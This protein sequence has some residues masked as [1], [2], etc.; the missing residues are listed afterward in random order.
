MT[1]I[2]ARAEID[3][4]TD[5]SLEEA[6]E[7]AVKVSALKAGVDEKKAEIDAKKAELKIA[8]KEYEGQATWLRQMKLPKLT[9]VEYH[10]DG[11]TVKTLRLDT[12]EWVASRP[13]TKDDLQVPAFGEPPRLIPFPKGEKK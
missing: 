8:E 13:A 2:I 5:I 10:L 9:D 6:R 3:L 4:P 1:R 11:S 7:L 12:G